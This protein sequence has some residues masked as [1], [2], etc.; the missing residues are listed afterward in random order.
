MLEVIYRY[1]RHAEPFMWAIWFTTWGLFWYAFPQKNLHWFLSY[2]LLGVGLVEI[3]FAYFKP[4]E[5]DFP[6]GI[7]IKVFSYLALYICPRLE[8][9]SA[10]VCCMGFFNLF[11]NIDATKAFT[12]GGIGLCSTI[13]FFMIVSLQ[14]KFVQQQTP[15][16]IRYWFITLGFG[17]FWISYN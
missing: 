4:L 2:W 8:S 10:G 13:L 1:T 15:L 3:A 16:R 7:S 5:Y 12:T 6:E 9:I 14:N 11:R 17:I